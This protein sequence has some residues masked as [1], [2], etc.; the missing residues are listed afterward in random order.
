VQEADK[1]TNWLRI[2]TPF[3]ATGYVHGG[4]VRLD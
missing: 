1:L 4:F 2:V 3:G